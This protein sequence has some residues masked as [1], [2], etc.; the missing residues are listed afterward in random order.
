MASGA[1]SSTPK[2]AAVSVRKVSV[3]R[4]AVSSV[5]SG[6][7]TVGIGCRNLQGAG[8]AGQPSHIFHRRCAC[9]APPFQW[10]GGDGGTMAKKDAASKRLAEEIALA[11]HIKKAREETPKKVPEETQERPAGLAGSLFGCLAPE[12]LP[13]DENAIWNRPILKAF[14]EFDLDP[15]YLSEWHQLLGHLA[16]VLFPEHRPGA[17]RKWTEEQLCRLLA[18]VAAYKR[19]NPKAS[20]TAICIRL[21]KNWPKHS[22]GRLRRVLQDARNPARNDLLARTAYYGLLTQQM[23]R[24]AAASCGVTEDASR[25]EAVEKN[26]WSKAFE[27]AV[28]KAI[29]EADKLWGH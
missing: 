28:R 15:G 22:P 26:V 14:K 13:L 4:S 18:D 6:R 17:P 27:A 5:S 24:E 7:V 20:D 25:T 12:Y 8:P 3:G 16:Y 11:K 2:A 10:D 1:S 19:K 9:P 23:L 21:K 29:E